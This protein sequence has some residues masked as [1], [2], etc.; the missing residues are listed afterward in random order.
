MLYVLTEIGNAVAIDGPHARGRIHVTGPLRV[1]HRVAGLD[2]VRRREVADAA[3]EDGAIHRVVAVGAEREQG[4][5]GD[6]IE[7]RDVAHL[8]VGLP[9]ESIV[10]EEVA[11]CGIQEKPRRPRVRPLHLVHRRVLVVVVRRLRV[12]ERSA[13]AMA[14]HLALQR[15]VVRQ[16]A[17]L[18][19][20][21]RDL[22]V[23]RVEVV[24]V[25]RLR[26]VGVVAAEEVLQQ[27]L[28]V[29]GRGEPQ[30]VL[31]DRAGEPEARIPDVV[32]VGARLEFRVGRQH[33]GRHRRQQI[34][35]Q[36]VA[37][38][39][40]AHT[41]AGAAEH[42]AAVKLIRAGLGHHVE[43]ETAARRFRGIVARQEIAFR[44]RIRIEIHRGAVAFAVEAR[45]VH[46]VD[47]VAALVVGA[48]HRDAGLQ[49]R[50]RSAHV[51]LAHGDARND[52]RDRPHVHA[53]GQRL[54]APL[55]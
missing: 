10:D 22:V 18:I 13:E 41:F 15:E 45:H 7:A 25:G 33:R 37:E 53:V 28:I 50:F 9:R 32:D 34:G 39:V 29:V 27:L 16:L 44:E 12:G 38:V 46:A 6:R 17:V 8:H 49:E 30:L 55:A 42:P 40:E 11:G 4:V 20:L 48:S 54:R 51:N 36:L 14:V 31:L 24:V 35:F 52:A 5:V 2:V 23:G 26:A 1:V 43:H 21:P 3:D 47:V 19:D